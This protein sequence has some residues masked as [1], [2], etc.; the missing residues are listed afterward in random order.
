[1][2]W[3]GTAHERASRV[4][5]KAKPTQHSRVTCVLPKYQLAVVAEASKG[6]KT[7]WLR[8]ETTVTSYNLVSMSRRILAAAQPLPRTTS[9]RTK[10]RAW[11]ELVMA[12]QQALCTTLGDR[13]TAGSRLE[14]A[15][16]RTREV[17]KSPPLA[18]LL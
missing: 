3:I 7:M 5:C 14:R 13:C 10:T 18:S 2:S 9:L 6:V 8:G 16:S 11:I 17:Q 15:S 1:M 4:P 12:R